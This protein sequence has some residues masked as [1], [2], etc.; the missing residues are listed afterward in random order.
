MLVEDE[1]AECSMVVM[2]RRRGG[3]GERRGN[4]GRG[5]LVLKRW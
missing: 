3:G 2:R 5:E 4:G 1:Q